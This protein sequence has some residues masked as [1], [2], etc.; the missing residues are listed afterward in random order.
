M[1]SV[2]S[3]DDLIFGLAYTWNGEFLNTVPN[4][5]YLL[6]TATSGKDGLLNVGLRRIIVSS[7]RP[8]AFGLQQ[9]RR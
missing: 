3:V 9:Q 2:R 1:F 5:N 4:I 7:V 8:A 6:V